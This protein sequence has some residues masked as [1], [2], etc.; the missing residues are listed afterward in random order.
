M[1]EEWNQYFIGIARYVR[2]TFLVE[3]VCG[4]RGPPPLS[5]IKIVYLRNLVAFNLLLPAHDKCTS[6]SNI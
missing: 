1:V 4:K 6:H 5:G 2:G 3:V